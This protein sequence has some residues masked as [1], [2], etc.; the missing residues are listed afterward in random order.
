MADISHVVRELRN[1]ANE[2]DNNVSTDYVLFR[3]DVLIDVIEQLFA[4]NAEVQPEVF[5]SL[6]NIS[7]HIRN[8][9]ESD[10][11]TVGRPSYLLPI[12]TIETYLSMGQTAGNIANLFGVSERTIRSR[13]AQHGLRVSDLF[14]TLEDAELDAL[15]E[16]VLKRHP[17]AGYKMMI[18][19]LGS[20]GIRVQ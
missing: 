5:G 2:V 6:L 16:D 18:G 4:D 17:N 7:Q 20:Q 13:M 8:Q 19:H 1:L 9:C 3:L 10:G 14:S 15:V 11:A 12:S